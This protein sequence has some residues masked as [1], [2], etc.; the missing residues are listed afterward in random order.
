M[1]YICCI[2]VL[3]LVSCASFVIED[4][5]FIDLNARYIDNYVDKYVD[6][7][8]LPSGVIYR[9]IKQGSDGAPRVSPDETCSVRYIGTTINGDVFTSS[10]KKGQ[11]ASQVVPADLSLEGWR[12]ALSLMSEG[13]HWE[14][15]VPAHL[16]Y[17]DLSYGQHV[18]PSSTLVFDLHVE[19]ASAYR[20]SF[21]SN[22]SLFTRQALAL[23]FLLIYG[24]YTYYENTHKMGAAS[25]AR[26]VDPKSLH[27]LP[28]HPV[29][30]LKVAVGSQILDR[31]EIELFSTVC[32]KTAE[33]F[34]CLVRL[35]LN[36]RN[37]AV[38]Q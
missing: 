33:N 36:S 26:S 1:K 10:R 25:S 38:T 14:V 28:G 22:M 7:V 5:E 19:S 17:G 29:V 9:V 4:V 16:G 15:V 34:R 3:I 20:F 8:R 30:F 24:G 11:R 12:E 35:S 13:D 37:A 31:V 27:G 18:R 32:P 23:S 6:A 2:F 21:L